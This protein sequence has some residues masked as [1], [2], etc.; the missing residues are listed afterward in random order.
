MAR[1]IFRFF[2]KYNNIF[3]E[4][5]GLNLPNF[6][7]LFPRRVVASTKKLHPAFTW[8]QLCKLKTITIAKNTNFLL[9]LKLKIIVIVPTMLKM[10]YTFLY[11]FLGC[12]FNF[13]K[14]KKILVMYNLQFSGFNWNTPNYV[15]QN[16]LE[17]SICSL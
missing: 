11:T 5:S 8:L 15:R 16:R 13:K 14:S 4:F 3:N 12:L 9:K 6:T 17:L 10:F 2:T 1:V 7:A